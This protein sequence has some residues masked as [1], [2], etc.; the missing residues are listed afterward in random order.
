MSTHFHVVLE[1]TRGTLSQLMHH[2]KFCYARYFNDT[3]RRGG[4]LFESRFCAELLD[5]TAYFDDAVAYV[6]LNPV[7]TTIPM[8]A[9]PE[10]HRW[11]SAVLVCSE[12]TPAAFAPVLLSGSGG[13]DAVL[14]ALPPSRFKASRE[15][16]CHRLDVLA[17][18]AWLDRDRVLAGRSPEFYRQFLAARASS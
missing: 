10:A 15:R 1:D 8:A 13:A 18:G 9:S 7:R 3:H 6:L 4:P 12:T 2:L 5:S 16:R 14:A 17:S 11:S